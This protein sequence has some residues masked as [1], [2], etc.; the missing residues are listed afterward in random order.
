MRGLV[1]NIWLH[2]HIITLFASEKKLYI[3]VS[4]AFVA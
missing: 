3:T 1:N 4:L 2:Y